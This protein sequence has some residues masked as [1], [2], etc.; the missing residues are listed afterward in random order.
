MIKKLIEI[1]TSTSKSIILLK[2]FH[3]T[4]IGE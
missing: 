3:V 1:N 4:Y 2:I